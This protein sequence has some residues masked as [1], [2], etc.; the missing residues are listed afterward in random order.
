MF[1]LTLIS[2]SA[3]K[4]EG[5]ISAVSFLPLPTNSVIY[6][7]SL[8][9]SDSNLLLKNNFKEALISKGF[10]IGEDGDLVLTFETRDEAGAWAGGGENRFIEW[11]NHDDQSGV[12]A[13]RVH[14]NLF[15]SQRGGIF[16]SNRKDITRIVTPN[17]FNIEVTIDKKSN[18]NRIWQGWSKISAQN[19]SNNE[20]SRKMVLVLVESLGRTFSSKSFSLTQ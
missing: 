17:S 12:D 2:P 9:N 20:A 7:R 13:P 6:L 4:S 18:G 1:F 10:T 3:A 5:L 14:L 8:D 15:N 16:N 11:S 19:T